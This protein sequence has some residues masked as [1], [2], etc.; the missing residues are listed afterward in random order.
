MPSSIIF[1]GSRKFQPG[2]YAKTELAPLNQGIASGNLAIVGDFPTLEQ[3]VPTTY[4]G[5]DQLRADHP[6][7]R[8]LL[9]V[10][11]LGFDPIRTGDSPNTITVVNAREVERAEAT[12]LGGRVKVEAPVWGN[13]GNL[14]RGSLGRTLDVVDVTL[15]RNGFDPIEF[16]LDLDAVASILFTDE[17]TVPGALIPDIALSSLA[18]SLENDD[19]SLSTNNIKALF[20][21][22]LPAKNNAEEI[23]YTPLSAGGREV[24]GKLTLEVIDAN[25][26]GGNVVNVRI[27][28]ISAQGI[29]ITE[30]VVLPVS[31]GLGSSIET[32]N[33][34]SMITKIVNISA[35]PIVADNIALKGSLFDHLLS[36]FNTTEELIDDINSRD[37]FTAEY[38]I[39]NTIEPTSL[40]SIASTTIISTAVQLRGDNALL[41]AGLNDLSGGVMGTFTQLTGQSLSGVIGASATPTTYRLA[42]GS[43][44]SAVALSD[45]Q[46]ALASLV[47]K[48]VHVI[49]VQSD[50]DD[51]HQA[52]INHI[53]E[54]RTAGRERNAWLGEEL[55]LPLAT[56]KTKARKLNNNNIALV[57]QGIK[58]KLPWASENLD[59]HWLAFMLGASQCALGVGVPLTRKS[60]NAR[61][62]DTMQVW[63]REKDVNL[64][65]SQ[66]LVVLAQG[67][68]ANDLRIERSITTWLKDNNPF[69]SEVSAMDSINTCIRDLRLFLEAEIGSTI[70]ASTAGRVEDRVRRRLNLQVANAVIA[71]FAN[72]QVSIVGDIAQ[73]SFDLAP[74]EPLNFITVVATIGRLG[75]NTAEGLIGST[76]I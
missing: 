13:E 60:L 35:D 28:G 6:T 63:D 50:D 66:G 64:A 41:V 26:N 12:I 67:G 73:V 54:A 19:T 7:N 3:A 30:E 15:N 52:V 72:I 31:G 25:A 68:I 17:A 23:D 21:Q 5:P 24:N 20:S 16:S 14:V 47:N 36:A 2:V 70:S 57:G 69:Y 42:G 74:V 53:A 61:V 29:A 62:F 43:E 22:T 46:T 38:L 55:N 56:L 37:G 32:A 44:G 49:T 1:Q 76:S 34:Y 27:E 59:P 11:I 48:D 10:A 71:G 4:V 51:V 8:E 33:S 45:Y 9:K 39:P 58:V 18:L 65:I 40:D 75:Q